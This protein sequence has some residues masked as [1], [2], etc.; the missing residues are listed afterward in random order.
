MINKGKINSEDLQIQ[1]L[2]DKYLSVQAKTSVSDKKQHL[3]DDLL[4]AFVEGTLSQRELNP[5]VSHL[6]CC[7]YCRHITAELVKLEMAFEHQSV[8]AN[9]FEQQPSK[10]SEVL[11][12]IL[13]RFFGTT[14]GAVFAHQEPEKEEETK[15]EE[16]K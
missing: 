16:E 15:K 6:V 2:L 10:V 12:G 1:G 11:N 13:S 7:S 9:S 14:D 3:D 8:I 4:T 5:T